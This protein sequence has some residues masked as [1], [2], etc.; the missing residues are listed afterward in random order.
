VKHIFQTYLCWRCELIF[1]LEKRF[2]KPL[3][4]GWNLVTYFVYQTVQLCIPQRIV[5]LS[6]N[7][8][9]G[10]NLKCTTTNKFKRRVADYYK[11]TQRDILARLVKGDLVHADE[12]KA[13]IKGKLAYVWVFTNLRE[14]AYIYADSREADV[15]HATLAGFNGVLVS[16]FYAAYDSIECPQQKCLMHLLRDLNDNVLDHPYDEELK[17]LVKRFGSLVRP[18]VETVDRRGLKRHFLRKHRKFV[19]RFF[20]NL[21]KLSYQSEAALKCKDRFEKN[22]EKLFTFLDHDGIPWNNNNAENAIK[23][24]AALRNVMEGTSTQKGIDEYLTLLS[25]CQTCKYMGVDFLDFLR[26]GEKDVHAFAEGGR[27]G[28]RLPGP[29]GSPPSNPPQ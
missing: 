22:R 17:D 24:F 5:T 27:K 28:R 6:L 23:A 18:M 3:K 29:D 20:R 7:Q 2:R 12:T 26:S 14:V 15:L 1:G 16:D 9:F 8:L 19:D 4:F 10:F 21:G 11:E 13:N 25:V